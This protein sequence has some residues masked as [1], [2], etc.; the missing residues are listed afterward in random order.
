MSVFKAVAYFNFFVL[1]LFGVFDTFVPVQFLAA[2]GLP[3]NPTTGSTDAMLVYWV[4]INGIM[5]I[6]LA[7]LY[8]YAFNYN[9][10][11]FITVLL[12]VTGMLFLFTAAI[13][14]FEGLPAA[15]KHKAPVEPSIRQ[16]IFGTV[17]ALLS[18]GA[19]FLAPASASSAKKDW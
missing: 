15:A 6:I 18:F 8:I 3:L 4:Q 9:E 1:G 5:Y 10:S 13:V 7:C 14:Y 16:A 12:R 11:K 17:T 19:S 2:H